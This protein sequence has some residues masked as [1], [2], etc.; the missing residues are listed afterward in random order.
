MVDL[1]HGGVR[2]GW[3]WTVE[4]VPSIVSYDTFLPK[5]PSDG[6]SRQHVPAN[7]FP[8]TLSLGYEDERDG[9]CAARS[10]L[11]DCAGSTTAAHVLCPQTIDDHDPRMSSRSGIEIR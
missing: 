1:A 10:V 6:P 4:V 5:H 8:P 7:T 2:G 3:R 9:H 11:C